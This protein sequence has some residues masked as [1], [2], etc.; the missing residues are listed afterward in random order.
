[1][2]KRLIQVSDL[3]Q[4]IA[5]IEMCF[6]MR[7]IESD[8]SQIVTLCQVSLTNAGRCLSQIKVLGSELW[9]QP[10]RLLERFDGLVGVASGQQG[11]GQVV[12][13]DCRAGTALSPT[14]EEV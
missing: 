2:L 3:V 10:D 8:R 9:I 11:I 1:V 6:A 12:P 4:N 7:R 5:K 14:G 13:G